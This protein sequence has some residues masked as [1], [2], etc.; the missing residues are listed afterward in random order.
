MAKPDGRIEKGQRLSTAISARAW[1]R[2]QDA[3]DIVLGARPGVEAGQGRFPHTY[4]DAPVVL[5]IGHS[6]DYPHAGVA[7]EL[8][9]REGHV[10]P[11]AATGWPDSSRHIGIE[12]IF[13]DVAR[14]LNVTANSAAAG[15]PT[16]I[17][18]TVEPIVPGQRV[19]RCAVA[20]IVPAY[21]RILNNAHDYASI[22]YRRYSAEPTELGLLESSQS[23]LIRICKGGLGFPNPGS[24]YPFPVQL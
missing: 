18:I 9:F 4:I 16:Q 21:I 12:Y 2:A 5:P 22:R 7:V 20:G 24:I 13:G 11:A 19:V 8:K 3:A 17:A 1:N 14:M 23:G 6:Y 15:N 10:N